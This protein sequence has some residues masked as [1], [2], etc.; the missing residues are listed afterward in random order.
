MRENPAWV[1]FPRRWTPGEAFDR[2]RSAVLGAA[3]L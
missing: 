1:G 2:L 3:D